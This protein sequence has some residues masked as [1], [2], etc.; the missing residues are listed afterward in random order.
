MQAVHLQN[1]M[2]QPSRIHP[3]RIWRV[4]VAVMFG[5]LVVAFDHFSPFHCSVPCLIF[6]D[7]MMPGASLFELRLCAGDATRQPGSAQ[8]FRIDASHGLEGLVGADIVI[9]PFWRDP[10]ERPAQPLLDALVAARAGVDGGVDSKQVALRVYE[11]A[12]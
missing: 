2:P 9:I 4:T 11:R 7:T 3:S 10:A 12:T 5:H 8:G 6:G 1:P